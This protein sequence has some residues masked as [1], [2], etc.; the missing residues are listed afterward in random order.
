MESDGGV[1]DLDGGRGGELEEEFENGEDFGREEGDREVVEAADE[2]ENLDAGGIERDGEGAEE[3]GGEAVG[4]GVGEEA[5]HENGRC[6]RIQ[7][8]GEKL[9]KKL[10]FW[11]W[12]FLTL[13]LH[14]PMFLYTLESIVYMKRK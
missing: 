9:R 14:R 12:E 1:G 8:H 3:A 4:D 5:L 11:I 6:A 10:D 2:D 13:K 7:I